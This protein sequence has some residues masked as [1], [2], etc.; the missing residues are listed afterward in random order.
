ATDADVQRLM[1]FYTEGRSDGS[2]ESGIEL[3]IRRLLVTPEFLF[4]IE[5]EPPRVPPDTNYRLS[6]LE[7][8]SR[9]SFFL[10]SSLPDDQLI[11]AA[12]AGHLEDPGRLEREVRRMLQDPRSRALVD[13]F[14]GQWLQ[15]RNLGAHNPSVPLYPDVDDSLR[16]AFRQ[17]THL[18]VDSV[19]REDRSVLDLLTANY[20]FVNERLALHY[21]IPNVKGSHFRRVTLD[22]AHRRGLLGHGSILT[23]T[24]R[25]NRTSPVL[26]GKWILENIL[27]TPPPSPPPHVPPFPAPAA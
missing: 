14:A 6:D 15:T 1:A 5:A 11:D 3:A 22:Q 18:F 12:A 2:F 20:T 10:W 23:V 19:L 13:N 24:S 17:E 4:R 8:A 27:G 25:P 16:E 21:G 7:L 9:L 26:R